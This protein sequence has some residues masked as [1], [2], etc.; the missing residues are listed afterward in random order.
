MHVITDLDAVPG[1]VA[2]SAVTIGKFD[3]LHHGHLWLVEQLHAEARTRGLN[4]VVVTFDR[5]PLALLRPEIAPQPIVSLQQKL[6]LLERQGLRAVV[7]IPFTAAFAAV[8]P[9]RF[10]RELLVARL[11]M[12]LLVVGRDFRFGAGGAGDVP[13][14]QRL[15]PELG[16]EVVIVPDEPGPH[17]RRAS[18]TW[19]RELL[20]DG[21]VRAVA[22]VLGRPHVLSG[23]VVH[24]SKRGRELGFPTANLSPQLEGLIPADG[25]YAG[26]FHDGL[27][28]YPAA[29][30]IGNNPTFDG[31]PQKQV[32]AHL[33]DQRLDLYGKHAQLAFVDRIRGM[34]KFAG[35]EELIA[36]MQ[37]DVAA[38][39]RILGIPGDEH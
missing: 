37:R 23:E 8:T 18:S 29:I 28:V 35:I 16:Y 33:I 2:P 22:E 13:L 25:V 15:A 11:G 38:A 5:H 19:V 4:P 27:S 21:D 1:D 14:L 6:D 34:E 32:E 36:T 39:R 10:V 20:A 26:W 17:G 31:V 24:G 30:S 7:V 9:E 12:R 3:G